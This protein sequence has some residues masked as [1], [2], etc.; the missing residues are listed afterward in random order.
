M[1]RTH[2]IEAF[3]VQEATGKRRVTMADAI[4]LAEA[5]T[6]FELGDDVIIEDVTAKRL[7][8][9]D[10]WAVTFILTPVEEDPTHVVTVLGGHSLYCHQ[11][12]RTVA[13]LALVGKRLRIRGDKSHEREVRALIDPDKPIVWDLNV[14]I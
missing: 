11:C 7:R 3:A 1:Q 4:A 10:G 9:A 14:G 5:R 2:Y 6:Y 8:Q 12:D 13:T